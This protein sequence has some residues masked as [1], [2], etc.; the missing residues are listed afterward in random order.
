MWESIGHDRDQDREGF[1]V[2]LAVEHMAQLIVPRAS[3]RSR[4]VFGSRKSSK[5]SNSARTRDCHAATGHRRL[6]SVGRNDRQVLHFL[7]R[8]CCAWMRVNTSSKSSSLCIR[9]AIDPLKPGLFEQ[10]VEYT[11]RERAMRAATL[12]CQIYENGIARHCGF[13]PFV[14]QNAAWALSGQ[15]DHP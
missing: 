11:P 4:M 14:A 7:P 9:A 8:M 10:S 2:C 5:G 6:A 1:L 15:G 13:G 3:A 12:Q